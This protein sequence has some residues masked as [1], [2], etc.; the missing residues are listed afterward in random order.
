MCSQSPNSL[1]ALSLED[2]QG[3]TQEKNTIRN[4]LVMTDR[5]RCQW[6]LGPPT[7]FP[8]LKECSRQDQQAEQGFNKLIC[9]LAIIRG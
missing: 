2:L 9:I 4:D 8:H 7:V 3:F 5:T 6:E 1:Y